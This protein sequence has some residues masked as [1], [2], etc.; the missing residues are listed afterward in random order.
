MPDQKN[1][2]LLRIKELREDQGWS[3]SKL[4]AVITQ[5]EGSVTTQSISNWERGVSVPGGVH[6]KQLAKAFDV[7]V[8]E[9]FG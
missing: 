4:V 9:L 8:P 1:K 6:L 5:N 7:T 2:S 3:Q